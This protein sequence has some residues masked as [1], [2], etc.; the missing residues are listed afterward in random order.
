MTD[1]H[2]AIQLL[3]VLE[4][5]DKINT[6]YTFKKTKILFTTNTAGVFQQNAE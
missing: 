2:L 1:V 4:R 6:L 3:Q 5:V